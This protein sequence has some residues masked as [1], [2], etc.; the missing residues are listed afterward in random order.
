VNNSTIVELAKIL[1]DFQNL[2]DLRLNFGECKRIDDF[3]LR[4]IGHALIDV[5]H[6]LRTLKLSFS[7]CDKITD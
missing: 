7:H 5:S 3:G 4:E 2:I 1:A 6:S